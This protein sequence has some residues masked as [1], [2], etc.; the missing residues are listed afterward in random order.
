MFD[1]TA[2]SCMVE[3]QLYKS[4]KHLIYIMT[5]AKFYLNCEYKQACIDHWKQSIKC[6]IIII[7]ASF[8]SQM[9]H[10]RGSKLDQAAL[11]L[12]TYC[13]IRFYCLKLKK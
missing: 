9:E 11:D 5:E 7:V 12:N 3:L 6:A 8:I 10:L 4:I 13:I 1:S 2:C